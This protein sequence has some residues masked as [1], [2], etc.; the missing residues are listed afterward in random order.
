MLSSL[1]YIYAECEIL[2]L[3]CETYANFSVIHK[4]K[5]QKSNTYKTL[6]Y[7]DDPTCKLE[8]SQDP[9][10]KSIN[11]NVDEEICELNNKSA[12]DPVDRVLIILSPG[13]KFYSPSYVERLV[14]FYLTESYHTS[15]DIKIYILVAYE[16]SIFESNSIQNIFLHLCNC[17]MQFYQTVVN[18]NQK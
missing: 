4:N 9:K 13:W 18:P 16:I 5:R 10:C 12:Y 11:V 3:K 8:C 6:N 2:R 7:T 15:Y 1:L 14:C 17:L